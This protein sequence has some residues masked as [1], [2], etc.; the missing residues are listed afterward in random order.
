MATSSGWKWRRRRRPEAKDRAAAAAADLERARSTTR[1]GVSGGG[2]AGRRGRGAAAGPALG[3]WRA[4]RLAPLGPARSGCRPAHW[5]HVSRPH[6]PL[7]K[8]PVL[9]LFLG[10]AYGFPA[11]RGRWGARGASPRSGLPRPRRALARASCAGVR[12]RLGVAVTSRH[13]VIA[14]LTSVVTDANCTRRLAGAPAAPGSPFSAHVPAVCSCSPYTTFCTCIR[15]LSSPRL[16]GDC[17]KMHAMP[18]I[19]IKTAA[20]HY[21]TSC[22]H[23]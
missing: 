5:S 17:N 15:Y 16:W 3:R 18:R 11:A 6:R 8:K 2:G 13:E 20:K 1:S 10:V 22:L 23:S 4:P 12:W 21:P 9:R 14:R 19:R 7:P